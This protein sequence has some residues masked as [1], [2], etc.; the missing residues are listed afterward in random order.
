MN[1]RQNSVSVLQASKNSPTL[2]HL[3]ELAH[4]STARLKA[5]ESLIPG[6]LRSAIQ[7]GPIDGAEWCLIIQNNAAAAKIRQ[8]LPALESHLRTKGWEVNSIR[9]KVLIARKR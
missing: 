8:I 1:R 9:L 4:D 2:A 3:T 5:I 7:A 6:P